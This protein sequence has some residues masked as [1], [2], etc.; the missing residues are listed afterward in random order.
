MDAALESLLREVGGDWDRFLSALAETVPARAII[1]AS[2]Q[3]SRAAGVDQHG[4]RPQRI[5]EDELHTRLVRNA[6]LVELTKPHL[7]WL[8]AALAEIPHVLH[9][10]DRDGIILHSIGTDPALLEEQG[11]VPG[12]DWSERRM[13]T[14]GAGTALAEG[15]A[16]AIVGPEHYV[17]TYHTWTC[18]AAPILDPNGKLVGAIDLTTDN[19]AGLPL[20]LTLV[21]HMAHVVGRELASRDEVRRSASLLAAVDATLVAPLEP[22]KL[23]SEMAHAVVPDMADSCAI[24][25]VDARGRLRWTAVA[26]RDPLWEQHLRR[27]TELWQPDAEDPESVTGRVLR[28]GKPMRLDGDPL[29]AAVGN[30]LPE[31]AMR[32][33]EELRPDSMLIVPL[34]AR[35]NAS[36]VMYL[37]R[38]E[39]Q[40]RY[41]RQDLA[42]AEAIGVRAALA[43]EHA[44]LYEQAEQ[45]IAQRVRVEAELRRAKEAAEEANRAKDQFLAVVSHELRTPLTAILGYADLLASGLSG[46]GSE[47]QR[48]QLGRIMQ[49]AHHLLGHIEEIL[50]YARAEAGADSTRN[51][52]VDVAGIVA[53]LAALLEPQASRKGIELGVRGADEPLLLETDGG[54]VR[55][56]LTNL[57]GNALKFTDEGTVWIELDR[58][59]EHWVEVRVR[60]TGPGIPP[61]QWARIF[62]PFTQADAS[63]T[64]EKGGTGLGLAICRRFARM[65][66]GDVTIESRPG[67]GSTFTLRLPVHP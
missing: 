41:S 19:I 20:R 51:E 52:S 46:P 13:G 7:E 14:N 45:E 65:L 61:D 30:A 1:A 32:H 48:E 38:S 60:D 66:G 40:R 23:L 43:L 50:A 16:V 31:E 18:T 49:S 58:T 11:L 5:S 8:S 24:Y 29:L 62:E 12:F 47:R 28:T 33:F 67:A 21:G 25:P 6:A 59:L 17:S 22:K 39:N 54:R 36:G 15:R 27:I 2:W 4:T 10:T 53:E 57:V 63:F 55:Q 42:L 9:L 56:I 64:R 3:R 44:D 26:H 35:G 34:M 37:I